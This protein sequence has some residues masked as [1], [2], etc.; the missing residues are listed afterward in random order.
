MAGRKNQ[1]DSHP[2]REQIITAMLQNKPAT[3]IEALYGVSRHAIARYRKNLGEAALS[4]LRENIELPPTEEQLDLQNLGRKILLNLQKQQKDLEEIKRRADEEK[5]SVGGYISIA[6]I[7]EIRSS[8]D[9]L[10]KIVELVRDIERPPEDNKDNF[11][12][13]LEAAHAENLKEKE[14]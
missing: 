13:V 8:Y 9:T 14:G 11:I 10:L 6:A 7:R 12:R 1:I 2:Q 3:Q 5:V 4:Q